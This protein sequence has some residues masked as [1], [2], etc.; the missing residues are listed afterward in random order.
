MDNTIVDIKTY[1]QA[2]GEAARQ[3][4]RAMAAA[5]TNTKNQALLYIAA[6]ILREKAMLLNANQQD[7]AAANANGL[8]AVMLE[9][10]TLTEKSIANMAEGLQ[11]LLLC[12]TPLV[13]ER[14]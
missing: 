5:D 6:A 11:Q 3:A 9:R 13:D 12:L 10:L 2:V 7:C 14:F 8:E 4:S 1:M